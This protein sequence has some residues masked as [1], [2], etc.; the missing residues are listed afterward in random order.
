[1]SVSFCYIAHIINLNHIV[2]FSN[3]D[4]PIW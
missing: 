1:M 3:A 4:I 2:P